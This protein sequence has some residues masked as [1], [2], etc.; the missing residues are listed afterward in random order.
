MKDLLR[1]R[2]QDLYKILGV[3]TLIAGAFF[4]SLYVSDLRARI[5]ALERRPQPT[6]PPQPRK[7][8]TEPEKRIPPLA[9]TEP[10]NQVTGSAVVA[11]PS[12]AVRF[13]T[14]SG[15]SSG[16]GSSGPDGSTPPRSSP[17]TNTPPSR[18]SDCPR[19]T[20]LSVCIHSDLLSAEVRAP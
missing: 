20:L 9:P 18:S 12:G 7:S 14:G 3:V 2:L 11:L 6:A 13:S 19:G 17:P 5:G 15:S 16:G 4:A 8:P 10:G 1:P